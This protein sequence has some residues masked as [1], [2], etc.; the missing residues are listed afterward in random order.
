MNIQAFFE[1]FLMVINEMSPYLL[2][3]FLIAGVLHIFVPRDFYVRYLSKDNKF[4]YLLLSLS[5]VYLRQ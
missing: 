4:L 2:L 1:S 5:A 3:G